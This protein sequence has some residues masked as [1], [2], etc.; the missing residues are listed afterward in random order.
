MGEGAALFVLKRLADA[1]R[2]GD[3]IYAVVRGIGGRERRQGQGHH[4]ARTRSASGSRSSAP[5]A[6]SGLSPAACSLIEGHGTSTRVGDVVEVEQPAEAFAGAE[7]ARRVGRARLG[8]VQ[9]RP[10]QG[11]RR[12][13]PGMLKTTLALHHKVLPPSLN[14]E[15]PEPE[16]RL[17]RLAVRRQHRAARVGGPRRRTAR[18]R[19]ERVRL[20]R[21]ELPRRARGAR[22]R[23]P[24]DATATGRSIAVPADVP[25]RSRAARRRAGAAPKPPLRGALVLGARRRGGARRTSCAPRWPRRA[26]AATSTPRRRARPRCAR[27]SASRSTTP[28]RAELVAKAELALKALQARQPGRL[29]GAAR[30]AGSSAAAAPP[31]KVAFLYTGQGSQYANMLAEL[32]AARAGRRRRRS[33]RPTRSWRRCSRAG[34]LSDI[35]F[36]DPPTPPRWRAPRRSCGAPRSPSRPC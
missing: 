28:T 7:P 11:A 10:P 4:G 18:R 21:H 34:A 27:P 2:D 25:R 6:T 14:F 13:P 31:G 29:E 8:E 5:G 35:I 12:A 3:R 15:R 9:H 22:A 20:R 32:R 16:H 36:V 19:R 30:R 17:V 23:P 33:T 26:R 1:E 24:D